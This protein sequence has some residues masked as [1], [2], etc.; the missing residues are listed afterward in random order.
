MKVLKRILL[1]AILAMFTVSC[2]D[3]D[4]NELKAPTNQVEVYD[5]GAD[6]T[7]N[8]T[9]PADDS[10]DGSTDTGNGSGKGN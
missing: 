1:L 4:E 7:G 8:E 10:G 5:G 2:T 6:E 3:F 9:P